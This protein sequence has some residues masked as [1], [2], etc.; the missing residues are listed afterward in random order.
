MNDSEFKGVADA[1]REAQGGNGSDN[2]RCKFQLHGRG[3]HRV[4]GSRFLCDKTCE[5]PDVLL[6]L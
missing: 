5:T 4:H 2:G 6:W 3:R 1:E